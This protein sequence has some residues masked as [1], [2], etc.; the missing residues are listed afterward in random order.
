MRKMKLDVET[1][2]KVKKYL[3]YTLGE[4]TYRKD[5]EQKLLSLLSESLKDETIRKINKGVL[6]NCEPLDKLL[7]RA[8]SDSFLAELIYYF[9]EKIYSP[10]EIIYHVRRD[11]L[12]ENNEFP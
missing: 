10:G 1:R 5:D 2:L 9:Q 7:K 8:F 3:E 11:F 6:N 4:M 12:K